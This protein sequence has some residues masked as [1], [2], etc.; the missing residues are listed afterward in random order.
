VN[1]SPNSGRQAL[2]TN[3]G[4][5]YLQTYNFAADI[6]SRIPEG[7]DRVM[8][9]ASEDPEIANSI[10][11]ALTEGGFEHHTVL[12]VDGINGSPHVGFAENVMRGYM[13]VDLPVPDG[14]TLIAVKIEDGIMQFYL[15]ES[16]ERLKGAQMFVTL[17]PL[18][19][20]RFSI[21][22][23]PHAL[24]G[25]FH[26]LLNFTGIG[27]A[28][29][30]IRFLKVKI[31]ERLV[32]APVDALVNF[33]ANR[34]DNK[35]E[36]FLRVE[37][38]YPVISDGDLTT[39]SGS[40]VLLFVHGIFSSVEGAFDSLLEGNPSVMDKLFA[41]YGNRVIG[42]DHRTVAKTPLENAKDIL[43]KLPDHMCVDI[44][45]H[46]RG[47]AVTRAMLEHPDMIDIGKAKYISVGEVIFVAGANQGTPLASRGRWDELI[48]VFTGILSVT[49]VTA[50]VHAKVI[51]GLVKVM[52]HGIIDLPSL[53]ALSPD[54]EFYR[55]LNDK[56]STTVTEYCYMRANFDA[57]SNL[58]LRALNLLA[59]SFFQQPNDLVIPFVGA[60][61]FDNHI[62]FNIEDGVSYLPGGR[63][64]PTV[65]HT[66]FFKQQEVKDKLLEKLLQA[67]RTPCYAAKLESRGEKQMNDRRRSPKVIF[68]NTK[69]TSK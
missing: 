13:H 51:V 26:G 29:A 14:M 30:I 4:T 3:V 46:S 65:L 68:K 2:E 58:G 6:N 8:R 47:A 54:S 7:P 35:D 67:A 22:I 27:A 55:I 1:I 9:L 63:G 18:N 61:T 34:F 21:P 16:T 41:A 32:Q 43:S 48:N 42:W 44:V 64:Q 56:Y 19:H 33:L 53:A 31:I 49:G 11:N 10:E 50:S 25:N 23:A 40:R 45:C 17:P 59:D 36:R 69:S 60:G 38:K 24:G 28:H 37:P 66:N 39:M 20:V 12:T 52:A 62:T 15:P 5:L 57:P